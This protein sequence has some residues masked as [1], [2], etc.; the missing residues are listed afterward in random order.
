MGSIVDKFGPRRTLIVSCILSCG[1]TVM[2]GLA[3]ATWMGTIARVI[4]GIG[5][6]CAWIA[7]MQ[8]SVV[9]SP[10]VEWDFLHINF[11]F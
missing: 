5:A 3:H 1:S 7:T 4:G 9:D 10:C 2:F 11:I 8:V 6:G